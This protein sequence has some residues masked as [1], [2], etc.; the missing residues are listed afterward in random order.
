MYYFYNIINIIYMIIKNL[1]KQHYNILDGDKYYIDYIKESDNNII[2]ED[3]IKNKNHISIIKASINYIKHKKKNKKVVIKIAHKSKTNKK[4]YDISLRLKNIP[5]FIKY[6][7]IFDCFDES[8]KYID[9]NYK[10]PL[11]ICNAEKTEIYDNNILVSSYINTGSI[12]NYIWNKDNFYILKSLL[13]QCVCSCMY[14]YNEYGFIHGDLHLDNILFKKTNK[15]SIKYK[16]IEIETNGYKLIIMDFDS[17]FIDVD[18]KQNI[19]FYWKNIENVFSRLKFDLQN[20]TIKNI[21]KISQF[22]YDSELKNRDPKQSILLLD[23][24]D[25]LEYISTLV[26]K[27]IYNK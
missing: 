13:K 9:E 5:G 16:E 6:I 14:S 19:K 23:M 1:N 17:S 8:Y 25:N 20:I 2:P 18:I 27:I 21:D 3:I 4:E 12:K 22:N 10:I 7:C 15:K 11:K 26:S 24:I